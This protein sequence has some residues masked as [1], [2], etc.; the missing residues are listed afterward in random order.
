MSL[1]V[2]IMMGIAVWHFAIWVPDR[3]WGGIVGAFLAAIAGAALVGFILAG[4]TVPGRSDTE[5]LQ[6]FIAI[7]GAVF[8]LALSYWWGAQ[9]EEPEPA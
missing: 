2:W 6:A 9:Q 8:G 5:I 3:F 7:P 4:F 1:L